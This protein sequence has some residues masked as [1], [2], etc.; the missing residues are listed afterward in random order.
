M[1]NFRT[2]ERPVTMQFAKP[3][4]DEQEKEKAHKHLNAN[5]LPQIPE[6]TPTELHLFTKFDTNVIV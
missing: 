1:L 5:P 3:R 2:H 4:G 6:D